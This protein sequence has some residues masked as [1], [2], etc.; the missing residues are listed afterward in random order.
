MHQENDYYNR[1]FRQIAISHRMV[2]EDVVVACRAGGLEISGSRADGWR[3]GTQGGHLERGAR[4]AVWMTQQ[5]FE[6]FCGG[7]PDWARE[8]YAAPDR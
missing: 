4:R 3:R 5:E 1:L 2:R 7:L 6:A 8:A